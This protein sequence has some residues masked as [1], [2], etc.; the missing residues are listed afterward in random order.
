MPAGG[1]EWGSLGLDVD[2]RV[3]LPRQCMPPA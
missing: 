3:Q 2:V 1:L